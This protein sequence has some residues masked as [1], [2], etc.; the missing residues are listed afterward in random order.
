VRGATVSPAAGQRRR[1]RWDALAPPSLLLF[2]WVTD[3]LLPYLYAITNQPWARQRDMMATIRLEDVHLAF[4]A[5]VA[6]LACWLAGFALMRWAPRFSLQVRSPTRPLPA[7]RLLFNFGAAL[8][9]FVVIYALHPNA[10]FASRMELTVGPWG[11]VLFLSI[12]VLFASFWLS[13]VGLLSGRRIPMS[14]VLLALGMALCVIAAF[15]PLE[16]RARMLMAVLYM[17][18][19]W[20]YYVRALSGA[21]IWTLL[22]LGLIAALAIDYAR[23]SAQYVSIDAL[24]M[25]YGLAYGR[26]FDGLLNLAAMLRGEMQ[27]YVEHHHGAAWIAD[28]LN[29]VGVRSQHPDS[30]TMFMSEVL[31]T[32]RFQAGFPITRPGEFF[33]AFG[34]PGV[35]LGA[36]ILGALTRLWY[37]WV[38]LARP[39]GAASAPVYFTLLMTAGLVTQKN[40]LFS[41]LVMALL[42]VGLV[43]ALAFTVYGYQI[44]ARRERVLRPTRRW[45]VRPS[46]SRR[47]PF[48]TP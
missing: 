38:I 25:A 37:N 28:V 4:A 5:A 16:G 9:L 48:G 18:V 35:V 34:W 44:V 6:Y 26:Q 40:Y 39:F 14:H 47:A 20:H 22:A 30:R 46:R 41:S 23:L 1:I 17:I 2:F 21:T 7:S 15:A 31:R 42:H 45:A 10:H 11:K 8:A 32:P 36:A 3:L 12:G 29:D 24:E 13:A 27:G 43:L 19:V 33:L